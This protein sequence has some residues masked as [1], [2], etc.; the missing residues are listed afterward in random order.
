[1]A[2]SELHH[3][4]LQ[5]LL[6]KISYVAPRWRLDGTYRDYLKIIELQPSIPLAKNIDNHFWLTIFV[7][8]SE[9]L[10]IILHKH[11]YR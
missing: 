7:E 5:K 2:P 10:C 1:M 8:P 11:N 3:L 6:A 4:Q 9:P